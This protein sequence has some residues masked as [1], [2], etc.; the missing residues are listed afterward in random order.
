MSGKTIKIIDLE[1]VSKAEFAPY[2][3]IWG[4]EEGEPIEILENLI[5]YENNARLDPPF[6]VV[7]TGLLI[8]NEKGRHI[9]YFE[10]HPGTTEAFIP[11]EGEC[12]F[13]MA[14]CNRGAKPEP[15]KIKAFYLRGTLGV[16]LPAGNWHWPPIPIGSRVKLLLIRCG[17]KSDPCDTVELNEIGLDEIRLTL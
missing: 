15:D 4:R 1:N 5:Y 16:V 12:I 6:E 8:C 10:R 13:V 3:Q 14:P 11:I 17:T 7:D 9:K 2:G